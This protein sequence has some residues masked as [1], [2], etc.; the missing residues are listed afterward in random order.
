[1]HIQ[2]TAVRRLIAINHIQKKVCI[3]INAGTH[4]ADTKQLAQTVVLVVVVLS[5]PNGR[6]LTESRVC[7][8]RGRTYFSAPVGGSI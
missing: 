5:G 4:Q 7:V 2:A 1:M 8:L 3:H 6:K